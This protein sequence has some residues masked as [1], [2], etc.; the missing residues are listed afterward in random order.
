VSVRVDEQQPY[1]QPLCSQSTDQLFTAE[2]SSSVQQ[3]T[4]SCRRLDHDR[5]RVV[6]ASTSQQVQCELQL[7]KQSHTD[8]NVWSDVASKQSASCFKLFALIAQYTVYTKDYAP[9]LAST[10][11]SSLPGACLSSLSLLSMGDLPLLLSLLL[12]LLAA[13]SIN[14]PPLLSLQCFSASSIT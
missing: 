2:S 8:I 4:A 12:L 13:V 14:C 9:P 10:V 1:R 3:S 11:S 7:N 5:C 6:T